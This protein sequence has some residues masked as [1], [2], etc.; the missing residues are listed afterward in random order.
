M[1]CAKE[2]VI[3]KYR[4][5]WN[6]NHKSQPLLQVSKNIL[7]RTQ[8]PFVEFTFQKIFYSQW[9]FNIPAHR[10]AVNSK[11]MGHG[12]KQNP[13]KANVV[14]RSVPLQCHEGGKM[15]NYA[16]KKNVTQC[17][18]RSLFWEVSNFYKH[19]AVTLAAVARRQ[20][21]SHPH[22]PALDLPVNQLF[23]H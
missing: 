13:T 4:C 2:S 12:L 8:H 10:S 6:W 14:S 7:L 17:N 5:L 11:H 3:P 1:H 19:H 22:L 23:F 18:V 21:G 15:V 16:H 9:S 20:R